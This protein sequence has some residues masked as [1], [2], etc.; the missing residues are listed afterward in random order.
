MTLFVVI[1]RSLLLAI[2]L[3]TVGC[4]PAAVPSPSARESSSQSTP[5]S[6]PAQGET[7]DDSWEVMLMQGTKVG[8]G[9]TIRQKIE[10]PEGT[11]IRTSADQVVSF[12][13]YGE[14]TAQTIVY[15]TE[16]T[17]EGQLLS[18]QATLSGGVMSLKSKGEVKDGMLKLTTMT[19]GK[20]S[21]ASIPW[22]E[23]HCG[24]FGLEDS[25]RRKPMRPG[26]KR[27]IQWLQPLIHQIADEQLEAIAI[28]DVDVLGEKKKLLKIKSVARLSGQKIET[29][30][31]ADEQGRAWR[32][33]KPALGQET[34]RTS[35]Q[36]AKAK[37]DGAF[38]L[39]LSTIVKLDRP[40][41]NPHSTQRV[42][43]RARLKHGNPAEVFPLC[44]SQSVEAIDDHTAQV[45]VTRVSVE[46]DEAESLS[47]PPLAG[48]S[49]PNNFIQSDDAIVANMAESI[50]PDE[51]DPTKIALALESAVRSKVRNKNFSQAF[52]TA[53]DVA[54]TLEG[55][56][57]EHAVLL[58]ALCRARGVPARV[59]AG[60]VYYPPQQ[61][62]A[63]HMWTE[64]WLGDRWFPLDATL[65]Q[66]GIGGA[67]LKLFDSDL[68]GVGAFGAFLPVMNVLGQLELEVLEAE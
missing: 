15:S 19:E 65:G 17:E 1:R 62:F 41:E 29:I 67:H 37:S 54:K 7:L 61:G 36:V 20:R 25:L 27:R 26:E 28:E 13:R 55:D 45:T 4:A 34:Y 18:L 10:R 56:C 11:R 32:A 35:E 22:D 3:L 48:D 64:A 63:Y 50:A 43:Y 46:G 2:A 49:S 23:E 53:A 44:P 30:L 9:R 16:E 8:Y 60:L 66:G 68:E 38:D 40:L 59:A 58:A 47:P 12:K 52:A 42:V 14:A 5:A 24:Y 57:T 51:T 21:T 33:S 6:Q 31:Y 39:G